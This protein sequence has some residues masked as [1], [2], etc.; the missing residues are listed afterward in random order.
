MENLNISIV[1]PVES[2]K[3]K[4][5]IELFSSAVQSIHNQVKDC[6][7]RGKVLLGSGS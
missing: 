7:R 4:N 2:S 5:F 1:L 6:P 3:H